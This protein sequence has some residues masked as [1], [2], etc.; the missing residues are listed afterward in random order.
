MILMIVGLVMMC[1]I[2]V[3]FGFVE[4][5]IPNVGYLGMWILSAGAVY[6]GSGAEVAF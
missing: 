3:M 5:D 2:F 1:V 4:T 6:Y